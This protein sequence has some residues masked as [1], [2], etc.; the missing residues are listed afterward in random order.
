MQGVD[1]DEETVTRD[2]T[3]LNGGTAEKTGF[4]IGQGLA[5]E[6]IGG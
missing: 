1:L 2:I 4:G 3:T 5:Y 6:T